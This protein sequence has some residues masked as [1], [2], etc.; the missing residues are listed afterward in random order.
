M[1]L[2]KIHTI[3]LEL[4]GVKLGQ[5]FSN[6]HKINLKMFSLRKTDNLVTES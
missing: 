4:R 6:I 5:A 2:I 1:L 3:C